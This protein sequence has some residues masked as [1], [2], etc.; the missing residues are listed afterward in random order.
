M[1]GFW[2]TLLMVDTDELQPRKLR[3]LL[4]EEE[5]E[6]EELEAE[7]EELEE[8][9]EELEELL[10]KEQLEEDLLVQVVNISD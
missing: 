4:L 3:E 9:L 6:G 10:L 8:E 1:Q 5:V 7:G 2:T